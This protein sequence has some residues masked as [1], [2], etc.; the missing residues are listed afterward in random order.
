MA[1]RTRTGRP[2]GAK[3][4]KKCTTSTSVKVPPKHTRN[5]LQSI[6]ALF[7][8]SEEKEYP[9][10][11]LSDDGKE[12]SSRS[13]Q[14]TAPVV[15]RKKALAVEKVLRSVTPEKKKKNERVA[16]VTT[17]K[18]S[19][20]SGIFPELE[21]GNDDEE[22]AEMSRAV[23]ARALSFLQKL[24]PN[25][26]KSFWSLRGAARGNANVVKTKDRPTKQIKAT[27]VAKHKS[28]VPTH[29]ND[30]I[31]D[32]QNRYTGDFDDDGINSSSS[33]ASSSEPS[34]V[35]DSD[36]GG[37]ANDEE[38]GDSFSSSSSD[39]EGDDCRGGRTIAA[40]KRGG[41]LFEASDGIWDDE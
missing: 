28:G 30:S 21:G 24:K 38:E 11:P 15:K 16:A 19:A 33:S 41:R 7:F 8:P 13:R 4:E 17:G 6:A 2:I 39:N 9:T 18:S 40:P 22:D 20:A 5:D 3:R 36:S 10:T 29:R 34:L 23:Q 31:W 37:G 12:L 27:E 14:S 25:A 32:L 35:T 26:S 1:K